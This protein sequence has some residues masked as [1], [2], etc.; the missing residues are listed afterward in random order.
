MDHFRTK[1]LQV[2]LEYAENI[3]SETDL[4]QQVIQTEQLASLARLI[5]AL[6][7]EEHEL[8][9]L[10]YIGE[11]SFSEIGRLLHRNEAAVKK[12]LYRLLAGL[13]SRLEVT[14]E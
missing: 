8:I 7:E 5:N 6:S 12:S 4:L 1:R 3:P 11:L 2:P 9:R 14:H 13:Q 10:R